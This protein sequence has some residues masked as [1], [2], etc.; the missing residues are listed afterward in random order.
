MK[1]K[2]I[3]VVEGRDD[4][5]AVKKAVEADI[6]QTHGYSYGKKLKE[7]L[8]KICKERGIIILTDP[9]YVGKRIR[10][11]ISEFIPSAKHAF[12]PQRKAL[13]GDNIGVEN[14]TPEDIK[15]AILDAKPEFHDCEEE[16]NQK[17]IIRYG[18]SGNPNSK[19]LREILGERLGIGYGNAKAF[20][21]KLNS[22][23]IKR[24]DLE[25]MIEEINNE[26][27]FS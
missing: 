4:E 20:L 2:E 5:A 14:A 27:N 16:F 7:N 18:L 8:K 23:G 17:D 3:I 11:D 10:K 24:R 1:I 12:L 21:T 22:F 13:K 26:S 15:K 6:I 25:E 19:E 9:D